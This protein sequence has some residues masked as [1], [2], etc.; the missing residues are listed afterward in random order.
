MP[1]PATDDQIIDAGGAGQQPDDLA[2]ASIRLP[3]PGSAQRRR[4]DRTLG[5]LIG[6]SAVLVI[7]IAF[8]GGVWTE[9]H[10]AARAAGP[11]DDTRL[12]AVAQTL[13]NEY[14][15]G[16]TSQASASAFT[17]QI[18]Q[19]ALAG[20][21][22]GAG[23]PYTVYLPPDDAQPL[24]DTLSGQYGGIGVTVQSRNGQIA[25]TQVQDGGPAQHAGVQTG[26]VLVSA[27]EHDLRASDT[28]TAGN[29]IR[30]PVG[31]TVNLVVARPS[32]GQ[33]LPFAIVRQR[34]EAPAV[35]YAFDPVTRIAHLQVTVFSGVTT[36]QLDAALA[37]ATADGAQGYVLDL[38]ENGGGSVTAAQEMIGRFV[39]P[40][41]GP[42]LY[43]TVGRQGTSDQ[44]TAVSIIGRQD[45]VVSN[46][47]MV[48]LVDG[49]TASA[50]EIVAASL[51]DYH[52]ATVLGVPTFGKG[53]VQRIHTFDDGAVLKVTIAEWLTP[54]GQRLD[55]LG[56]H[57]GV[58]VPAASDPARGDVQYAAAVRYLRSGGTSDLPFGW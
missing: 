31:S 55:H 28:T 54:S 21:V 25:I 58:I 13:E 5:V 38:R 2:E 30:G 50:A 24:T 22:G 48:V 26:D 8:L 56:V 18:E 14:Y 45:G 23:D 39:S 42:A 40:T 10:L 3:T 11:L 29:L 12:N 52:R 57:I 44:T 33:Q 20:M 36:S 4:H 49:N 34:L 35:V 15:R 19:Q 16:P 51:G 53:S 46:L 37:Q 41:A 43:E 9:R 7:L 17:D 47:P 32:T 27:D 6:L 1:H